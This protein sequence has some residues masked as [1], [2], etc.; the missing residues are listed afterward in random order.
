MSSQ[1]HSQDQ[2]QDQMSDSMEY[3]ETIIIED[4]TNN[5]NKEKR[6]KR[7][8]NTKKRSKESQDSQER[9]K[10]PRNRKKR[11]KV[12]IDFVEERLEEGM[13]KEDQKA[14]CLHCGSRYLCESKRYDLEDVT[15]GSD[16][17][18]KNRKI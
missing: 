5:D 12:W 11:S 4:D 3:D 18:K 2:S 6:V 1:D 7:P 10:Q 9:V 13:K 15:F 16:I 8:R 17:E 14:R